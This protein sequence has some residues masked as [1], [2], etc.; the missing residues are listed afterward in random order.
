MRDNLSLVVTLGIAIV[1]VGV[2]IGVALLWVS[3]RAKLMFIDCIAHDR[4]AVEEPWR[5]FKSAGSRLFRV[6][7]VLSLIGM[8]LVLGAMALGVWMAWA[9]I[10][11]GRFGSGALLG[12]LIGGGLL[13]LF[14][15]LM[16]IADSVV[17]DFLAVSLYLHDETV[18]EA[19][20]RVT[21]EIFAG[22]VGTIV[23]FY[24]M[25]IALGMAVGFLAMVGTCLTCCIA[26]LPYIG[27]VILLPLFVFSRA[28]V[29][30][31]VEQFG[32]AWRLFPEP[33]PAPWQSGFGGFE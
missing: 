3:S 19:W 12:G 15:F 26:A 31:F 2:A 21:T 22:R 8:P 4:A 33:E 24:L 16:S 14:A 25:K 20:Q 13:L 28:Y 5:R 6:R 32:P 11:A 30:F 27:T 10:K 23:V 18:A 9:D 17:Q 7:L 29:M 1:V